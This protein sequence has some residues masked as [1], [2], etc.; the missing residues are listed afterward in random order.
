MARKATAAAPTLT[1]D[2]AQY[3]KGATIT[4]TMVHPPRT[5]TLPGT[6][7]T[8]PVTSASFTLLS[9]PTVG[10]DSDGRLYTQVSD[11]GTTAVYTAKA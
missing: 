8:A 6:V 5:V 7:D 3:A 4:A 11:D 10:P 1:V 2:K 9:V